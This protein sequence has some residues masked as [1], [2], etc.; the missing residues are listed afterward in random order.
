MKETAALALGTV[1]LAFVMPQCTGQK[2]LG[3]LDTMDGHVQKDIV[4]LMNTL[5]RNVKPKA[6]NMLKL[7]WNEEA[8]TI[9]ELWVR[10]C[11]FNHSPIAQRTLNATTCGEIMYKTNYA[12][13]WE[14]VINTWY[15]QEDNFT[16]GM[17]ER[18]PY[19]WIAHY[20]QL[21]WAQSH[22]VGCQVALCDKDFIYSCNFCPAGNEYTRMGLP[23]ES[24]DSCGRC[25][26]DCDAGLCTNPCPYH[27]K[28]INC[29][30]LKGDCLS[31]SLVRTGCQATCKCTT[32][33]K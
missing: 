32:E 19:A 16:Y 20:T 18:T 29:Q 3:H 21:V 4:N 23:Y 31:D 14:H 25:P 33:I 22:E 9:A 17:G 28:Y 30:A 2:L 1:L 10:K 12:A 6:A 27:D 7:K 13:S 24:G 15:K 5:R 8:A 11:N 26:K